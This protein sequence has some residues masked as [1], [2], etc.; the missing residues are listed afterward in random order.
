[1]SLSGV[2]HWARGLL[3]GI[4]L[5]GLV[6]LSLGLAVGSLA[7]GTVIVVR[8][9]ADQFQGE[10]PP[11]FLPGH[12]PWLRALAHFGKNVGGA[13]LV[14]A[15]LIMSLPG[16]PGQG[17]LVIL[18]GVSLL[19]VPGKRRLERRLV[20]RPLIRRSLDRLRLRFGRPPLDLDGA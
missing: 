5:W 1:V 8:W 16:V 13:L 12:P 6:A 4:G 2:A 3:G 11:P 15:G 7:I 10:H 9:P 20:A 18:I 17:L 14:L 19:D